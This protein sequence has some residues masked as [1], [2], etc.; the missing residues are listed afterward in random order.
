MTENVFWAKGA[1]WLVTVGLI[2]AIIPP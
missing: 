2:F 1:A